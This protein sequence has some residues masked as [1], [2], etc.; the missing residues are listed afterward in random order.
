MQRFPGFPSL[1]INRQMALSKTKSAITLALTLA[2]LPM[3]TALT[4]CSDSKVSLN[5]DNK[6]VSASVTEGD[7]EPIWP[8]DDPSIPDGKGVYAAQNCAQC[9]G[10]DGKPVGGG[11]IDLSSKE[12][13]RKQ[14]PVEQYDFIT[15]GKEGSNHVK[16][17]DKLKPSEIWNLVFYVR[18]LST[19]ALTDEQIA[20]LDPVFGANCAV[21]HGKKGFGNGPL[22]KGNT[23]EP[24]PAN[25]QSFP[26]FYD[27]TD[28]TLWDH[29]ANGI[30]W[31][32]MPN[33]LGKEDKAKNIKFDE[34]Y[35]WRL[36]GYIR[37]FHESNKT[38]LAT[39]AAH[40]K[41][42]KEE[43]NMKDQANSK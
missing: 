42:A 1:V 2:A 18:S 11:A 27:R 38:E 37:H 43:A 10:A 8:N 22:M 12:W 23:L 32:G 13:A 25:F 19:P 3:V 24:L 4:G 28:E 36:V 5:A 7:K 34:P 33:F 9:H 26:R 16:V 15:F 35:I 31:E 6:L 41:E 20:E 39:R 14:K 40:E 17:R 30:K 29:I 21:C